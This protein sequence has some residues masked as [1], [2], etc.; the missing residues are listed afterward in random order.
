[1]VNSGATGFLFET[2]PKASHTIGLIESQSNNDMQNNKLESENGGNSFAMV[3]DQS[4]IGQIKPGAKHEK[5][6][7]D[8]I[9]E[10]VF[11]ESDIA[12]SNGNK[13]PSDGTSELVAGNSVFNLGGNNSISGG[14]EIDIGPKPF[15][16]VIPI[17][18][19]GGEASL[20]EFDIT[21][22][23]LEIVQHREGFLANPPSD[24]NLSFENAANSIFP[25]DDIFSQIESRSFTM[26]A[27]QG[28]SQDDLSSG[29]QKKGD[30]NFSA[31]HLLSSNESLSVVD[32]SLKNKLFESLSLGERF[33][34]SKDIINGSD[35]ASG[36]A[37]LGKSNLDLV[38][39]KFA[40]LTMSQESESFLA[41]KKGLLNSNSFSEKFLSDLSSLKPLVSSKAN[42]LG[43]NATTIG[44]SG[45]LSSSASGEPV[46]YSN[47]LSSQAVGLE[48]S[49]AAKTLLLSSNSQFS[50]GLNLKSHFTPNLAMR[51]QW[52]F[53]RA[54]N[55]A[56]VMMDPPE[57]GPMTVKIQQTNGETQVMFQVNN[58]QTKDALES[59]LDKLKMLLQEQ[60]IN[61]GDAQVEQQKSQNDSHSQK[62][63]DAQQEQ[64]TVAEIAPDKSN[65]QNVILD[66]IVDVYS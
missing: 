23:P 57:L 53:N 36:K 35:L 17:K 46:T 49:E 12:A 29:N 4:V 30:F 41:G 51:I 66:S 31:S 3:F 54:V 60:G 27:F 5:G 10:P 56:E 21:P 24:L 63:Q 11:L 13:L 8:V 18:G 40:N 14:P 39:E 20:S 28:F 37:N 34:L 7:F 2:R 25:T 1:M 45:L 19:N 44:L 16:W 47:A 15:D 61:L 50:Q 58:P 32:K 52:M 22:K 26:I 42:G 55:S 38:N 43:A 9:D 6:R 65:H 33:K 59:N 62:K 48:A 64:E